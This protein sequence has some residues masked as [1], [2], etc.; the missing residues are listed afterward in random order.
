MRAEVLGFKSLGV[1]AVGFA[2]VFVGF[3]RVSYTVLY[4]L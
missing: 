4:R 2:M 1:Q 3:D